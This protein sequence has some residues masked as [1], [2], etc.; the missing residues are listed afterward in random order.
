MNNK[1]IILYRYLL[2]FVIIISFI[3]CV[4]NKKLNCEQYK[5]GYFYQVYQGD[6]NFIKR[7]YNNQEEFYNGEITKSKLKWIAPCICQ[8]EIYFTSDKLVEHLLNEPMAIKIIEEGIGYHVYKL[9]VIS[10]GKIYIDTMHSMIK[11]PSSSNVAI[12]K[13]WLL[14]SEA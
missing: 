2:L 8:Y 6:T 13:S 1:K 14:F 3:S 9:K 10:S 7:T 12:P 4:N 11:T 5:E